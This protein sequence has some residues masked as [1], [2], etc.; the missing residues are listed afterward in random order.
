MISFVKKYKEIN[1]FSDF[2]KLENVIEHYT[3]VTGIL[4]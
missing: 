2:T 1:D 3:F 4:Y